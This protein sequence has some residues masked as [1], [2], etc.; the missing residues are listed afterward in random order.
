MIWGAQ[1]G[2]FDPSGGHGAYSEAILILDKIKTLYAY[3]GAK[4]MCGN[5]EFTTGQFEG[6][7]NKI[8]L[9]SSCTGGAATFISTDPYGKHILLVSGAGGGSGYYKNEFFGDVGG[10]FAGDALG[11]ATNLDSE[12]AKKV[13]G[14]GAT[15]S[16]PG[17]GGVYVGATGWDAING[18]KRKYLKG[19]DAACSAEGSAG[20]GG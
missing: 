5:S 10:P 9:K 20:G 12:N 11:D 2:S 8:C 13:R 3:V 18:T 7:K 6:G 19:G 17:D 4:G 1:G 16:R 15:S 14:K